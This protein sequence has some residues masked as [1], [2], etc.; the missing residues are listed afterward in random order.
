MTQFIQLNTPD[1]LDKIYV[2]NAY[3]KKLVKLIIMEESNSVGEKFAGI[4]IIPYDIKQLINISN[5]KEEISISNG[6]E[7]TYHGSSDVQKP[8]KIHLKYSDRYQT[9]QNH[10]HDIK[11]DGSMV[12]PVFSVNIGNLYK[13]QHKD[14][15]KKNTLCHQLE[16]SSS[17]AVIDFYIAGK[18]FEL[19]RFV[20]SMY[21]FSFG[22]SL[23][24]MDPS[25]YHPLN[26]AFMKQPS[27]IYNLKGYK[28]LVRV[29]KSKYE[30]EPY[31]TFYKNINHHHNFL[32]RN[33]QYLNSDGTLGTRKTMLEKEAEIVEWF[34]GKRY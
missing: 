32:D 10:T 31:F 16:D 4:K 26:N 29:S 28:L 25:K 30:L 18:N 33:M 34:K 5:I 19:E 24:Y 8:S 20:N 22:F 7:L 15:I 27:I 9:I 13:N 21:F 2:L 23:E 6:M 3:G 1:K 11:E 14:S 17:S 12:I